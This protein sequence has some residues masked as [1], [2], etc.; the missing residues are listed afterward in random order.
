MIRDE[1]CSLVHRRG[2]TPRHG[3]PPSL[4][5]HA[6]PV[7]YVPRL[8]SYLCPQTEPSVSLP[9]RA[10]LP[11]R[12]RWSSFLWLDNKSRPRK[13]HGDFTDLRIDASNH[14]FERRNHY[15]LAYDRIL[16][17]IVGRD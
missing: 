11:T 9:A 16:A 14:D 5:Q 12:Q 3:T 7:T 10:L 17:R 2:P 13:V 1:Q 6:E 4:S 15:Q 8:I